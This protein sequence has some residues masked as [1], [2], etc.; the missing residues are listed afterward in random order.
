MK[1]LSRI[2]VQRPVTFV[3]IT[4]IV[5]GFG[6]FGLSRLSLN[7]YPDVSFPTISVYTTYDGVAP[8]DMETLV[9]RPIEELVGSVS[10][11]QRIRSLSS[12][13]ASVIK[14]YFNWGT[15]L[16]VAQADVR[17]QIDFARRSIPQDADS[18]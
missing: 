4:L 7:L 10:G 3:M 17:K 6:V 5:I 1:N 8:G 12:Q 2:A 15:D 16:F 13:G 14:L 18:P 11:L 9:T